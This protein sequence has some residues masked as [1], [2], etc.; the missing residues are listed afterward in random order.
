MTDTLEILAKK[1]R[2]LLEVKEVTSYYVYI[3]YRDEEQTR[4]FYVGKAHSDRM[5]WHEQA[6]I[7]SLLPKGYQVRRPG[8]PPIN[9]KQMGMLERE[10]ETTKDGIIYSIIKNGR[11]VPK[12]KIDCDNEADAFET[13]ICNG[14]DSISAR[15]SLQTVVLAVQEQSG[16]Q[17]N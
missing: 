7:R 15:A 9:V 3:L 5:G 6:V 10:W 1:I 12:R 17:N 14:A 4:P 2:A 11:K 8:T 16:L 13:E